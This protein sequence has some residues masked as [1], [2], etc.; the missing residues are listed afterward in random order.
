MANYIIKQLSSSVA[1]NWML[2]FKDIVCYK[3]LFK[4]LLHQSILK[5]RIFM[6]KN[7]FFDTRS[8]LF[9]KNHPSFYLQVRNKTRKK[10]TIH[11]LIFLKH[12]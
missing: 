10:S 5:T 7:K 6:T 4:M 11:N 1:L 3:Q 8:K 12:I 9:K 2:N